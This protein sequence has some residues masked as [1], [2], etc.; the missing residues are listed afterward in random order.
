VSPKPVR[1]VLV[2]ST[3]LR[4]VGWVSSLCGAGALAQ[5]ARTG[6]A[7]MVV[8]VVIGLLL[9]GLGLDV[10]LARLVVTTRGVRVRGLFPTSASA[11]D[12]TAVE[13]RATSGLN[14]GKVRIEIERRGGR[15][16]KL[17]RLQRY[18]NPAGWSAANTDVQAIRQ[19]LRFSSTD[20][21]AY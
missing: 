9:L 17:T 13:A 3:G 20:R 7:Q 19:A 4:L 5:A 12:I 8:L 6:S 14:R 18:A 1:L 15:T 10:A 16:I 11:S 21:P 2:P